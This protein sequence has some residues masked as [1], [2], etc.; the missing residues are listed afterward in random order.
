M[1]KLDEQDHQLSQRDAD[2]ERHHRHKDGLQILKPLAQH[3]GD[4]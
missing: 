1:S 2:V 4:P 3:A